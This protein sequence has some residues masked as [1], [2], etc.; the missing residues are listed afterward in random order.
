LKATFVLGGLSILVALVYSVF[1]FHA[2]FIRLETVQGWTSIII[3]ILYFGGM[4]LFSLGVIGEYVGRIYEEVK[5]RPLYIVEET[6]GAFDEVPCSTST[7]QIPEVDNA[8]QN[9]RLS[10]DVRNGR[11]CRG[12]SD[13]D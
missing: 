12:W 13:P 2:H 10:L 6:M 1:I 8:A 7:D 9:P 11:D 3:C 5:R 4:I